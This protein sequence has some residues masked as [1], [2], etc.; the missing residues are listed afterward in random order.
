MVGRTCKEKGKA[1]RMECSMVAKDLV[2][3]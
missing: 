1:F 2:E 3:P